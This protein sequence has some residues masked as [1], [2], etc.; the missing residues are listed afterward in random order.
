MIGQFG[1]RCSREQFVGIMGSVGPDNAN[2][3][4][5]STLPGGF[6]H[7][8]SWG[9]RVSSRKNVKKKQKTRVTRTGVVRL[10]DD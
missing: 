5:V 2:K 4:I 9:G 10:I 7:G 6:V 8:S 1:G 3:T